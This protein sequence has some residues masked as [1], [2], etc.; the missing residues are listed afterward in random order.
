[1]ERLPAGCGNIVARF[2]ATAAGGIPIAF[3]AHLDTVPQIGPIEVE[4]ADGVLRNSYPTILGSD[5]KAAVAVLL[6]AM[7][8]VV[9][10]ERPHAGI[11]LIFTPCEEI[12]LKGGAAL[13]VGTLTSQVGFVYD[14]TGPIGDIVTA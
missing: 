1:A 10:E 6:V 5:N 13:D 3:G 11:E 8:Q 12:G 9:Q 4:L 7:Q 14:H 2:T